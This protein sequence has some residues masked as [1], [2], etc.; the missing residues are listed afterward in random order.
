VIYVEFYFLS[1]FV[2]IVSSENYLLKPRKDDINFDIY[3]G[4]FGAIHSVL[5]NSFRF[6]PSDVLKCR[7]PLIHCTEPNSFYSV[8]PCLRH[9]GK[10]EKVFNLK[11]HFPFVFPLTL[12][13]QRRC[14][15]QVHIPSVIRVNHECGAVGVMIM[16]TILTTN[17]T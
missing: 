6:S 1:K 12:V 11:E 16:G 2:F 4:R 15:Y 3:L 7:C 17:T 10:L 5:R 14:Q 9:T 13:I 8:K